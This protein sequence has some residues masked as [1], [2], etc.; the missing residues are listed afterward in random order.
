MKG[1]S[2]IDTDRQTESQNQQVRTQGT[3]RQVMKEG[4]KLK[5]IQMKKESRNWKPQGQ[6][7]KEGSS[8]SV[9][10]QPHALRTIF[11]IYSTLF[12]CYY[13]LWQTD[14][15]FIKIPQ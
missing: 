8:S 9:N 3:S 11:Y 12:V 10:H 13:K 4:S 14:I 5:W 15:L 7:G 2:E 6:E 1:R